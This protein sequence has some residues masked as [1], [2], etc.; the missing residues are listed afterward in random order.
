MPA[1]VLI[2][3][4]VL[5]SSCCKCVMD[6]HMQPDMRLSTEVHRETLSD[7]TCRAEDMQA[8]KIKPA[9]GG[10]AASPWT[11]HQQSQV[12]VDRPTQAGSA[13]LT[14]AS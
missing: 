1:P 10:P 14:R 6:C 11:Y 12:N 9:I 2:A 4:V 7:D 8:D 3:G 13:N 5:L